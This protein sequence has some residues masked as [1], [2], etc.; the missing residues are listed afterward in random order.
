MNIKMFILH[1]SDR[2][3]RPTAPCAY[4]SEAAPASFDI[5]DKRS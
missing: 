3:Y 5:R 1:I 4:K 2:S